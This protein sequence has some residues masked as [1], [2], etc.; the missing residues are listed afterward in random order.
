MTQNFLIVITKKW[1]QLDELKFAG[2]ARLVGE[3][4]NDKEY[5]LWQFIE[6]D[7]AEAKKIFGPYLI[8]SMEVEL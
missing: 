8:K 3:I 2:K 4:T 5:L 1:Q 6:G 7:V